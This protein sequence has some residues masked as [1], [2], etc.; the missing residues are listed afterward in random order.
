MRKTFAILCSLAAMLLA[1]SC[2]HK[3]LITELTP[4]VK[5]NVVFDWRNSPD[6]TATSMALYMYDRSTGTPIR[7]IFDNPVGGPLSIPFGSYD[8]VC[9]DG[10]CA[11]WAD[12]HHTD[13]PELF[14]LRTA[15]ADVLETYGIA[16]HSMPRAEGTGAERVAR[17]PGMT[18]ANRQNDIEL[19]PDLTEKTIT[20]YPE[21]ITCHYIVDIYDVENI[22]AIHGASL[23]ATISGMAEGYAE[24]CHHSTDSHVTMPFVLTADAT[25]QSLHGQFLT[26]GECCATKCTHTMTVYMILNDGSKMYYNFDVTSQVASAP[27]PRH[28][29]IVIHGLTLPRPMTESGGLRPSVDEWEAVY[30][31]L[32]M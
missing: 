11:D 20:F 2:H 3:D 24:G 23:D 21:E 19:P 28:V 22:A 14:E 17:T 29:H 13:D 30:V 27:D 15:D 32:H 25:S 12:L 4:R 9:L 5:I 8:G 16:T 7:Y 1:S 31:D 6:T 10:D 18:W 26:F